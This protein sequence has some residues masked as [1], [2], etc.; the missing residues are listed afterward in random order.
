MEDEGHGKAGNSHG[1][2]S[3]RPRELEDWLNYN[4]YHPLSRKLAQALVGSRVTP[5][6]VSIA[7]GLAIILAALSYL[8]IDPWMGIGLGLLLHMGWH[9]LD[10]ADGDLARLTSRTSSTGEVVDG[11]CDYAGHIVLYVALGTM[12]VDEIGSSAWYYMWAAGLSRIVQ[13]M[14]Y[15]VQRRQYQFWVYNTPW[16][17]SSATTGQPSIA[18]MRM[19][20]AGY[21]HIA[22]TLAPGA[23]AVDGLIDR[24][25]DQQLESLQGMIRSKMKPVLNSTHLLSANYRTLALGASM[26]TGSPIYFF[27]FEALLLNIILFVSIVISRRTTKDIIAQAPSATSR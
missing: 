7:G 12:L 18:I 19:L 1:K 5:D 25:T 8:H 13:A 9:V 24:S 23:L 21:L 10:G 20:G 26:F 17:R 3:A 15:E 2:A 16:L 14:H 27:V 6:M 4:L 11:I 22:K